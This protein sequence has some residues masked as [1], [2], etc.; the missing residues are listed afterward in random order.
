VSGWIFERLKAEDRVTISEPFG[1]CFYSPA[2][3]IK[4]SF[5]SARGADCAPVRDCARCAE[6][7][8]PGAIHLYHGSRD[9][10]GLYLT[11]QLAA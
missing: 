2:D 3:P 5:C 7:Q 10:R 1:D 9:P 4:T 6:P 11:E 8:A